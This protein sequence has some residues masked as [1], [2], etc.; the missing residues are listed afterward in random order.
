MN[1]TVRNVMTSPVTTILPDTGLKEAAARLRSGGFSALP[2]VDA[3]GRLVGVLS[4]ADLLVKAERPAPRATDSYA[5]RERD[6]Q[7]AGTL[8]CHLMSRPA[9]TV[10]VDTPLAEAAHLMLRHGLKRLPVVDV[11]AR[12]VGIVSRGDLLQVFLRS[13]DEVRRDVQAR[14]EAEG[15]SGVVA[16]VE[17]GVVTLRGTVEEAGA[18]RAV[19]VAEAVDGV[20]AVRS[21]LRGR[22]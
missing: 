22:T 7:W 14:F 20:V 19:Q 21:L 2:V 16:S 6:A 1:A 3:H 10:G 4:E 15:L 12:P 5:G 18:R 17:D 13:G 9:V 8:A 11:A